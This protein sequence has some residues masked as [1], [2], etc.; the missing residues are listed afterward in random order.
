MLFCAYASDGENA[1]NAIRAA[2]M[3]AKTRQMRCVELCWFM[4]VVVSAVTINWTPD[5][6]YRFEIIGIQ[7]LLPQNLTALLLAQS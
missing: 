5:Y 1:N 3:M 2:I 6:G 4:F 7:P